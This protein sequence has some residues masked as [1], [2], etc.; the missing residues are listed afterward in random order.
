MYNLELLN[1]EEVVRIFDE[2]FVKQ[3]ENE[4]ITTIVLT[5]KRLL[6]LDFLIENEGLEVLRIA[7]GINYIKTKEVY[8]QI[9]LSDVKNISKNKYYKIVC[10][11]DMSFEFDDEELYKLLQC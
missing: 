11:N 6:F 7:R 4:K 3:N 10:K 8:F 1:N 5:N 9:N 2:I